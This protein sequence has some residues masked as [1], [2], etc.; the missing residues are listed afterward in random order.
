MDADQGAFMPV[1]VRL[2][3]LFYDRLGEAVTNEL[4]D[5]FNQVDAAYKFDLREMNE[6]NFGRFDAKLDQRV[7]DIRGDLAKVEARFDAKLDQRVSEIRGDLVKV[8]ARFDAKLDQRVAEVRGDLVKVDARIDITAAQLRASLEKGLRDQMR[9]FF[10]AWA[11]LLV[12]IMGLWL[13]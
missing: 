2:S 9:F 5:W 12:S 8:E 3:K 11:T 13:R 4:V 1:T 7:A 10:L 6:L